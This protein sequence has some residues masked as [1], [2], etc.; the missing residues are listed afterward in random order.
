MSQA[1]LAA[2][3]FSTLRKC[4][5]MDAEEWRVRGWQ[6]MR[7]HLERFG[8]LDQGEPDEATI[9]RMLLPEFRHA[10]RQRVLRLL[11]DGLAQSPFMPAFADRAET[12]RLLRDRFPRERASLLS[13]ADRAVEA[14]F[15]LLGWQDVSFGRP[16]DWRLEPHAGK[17]TALDHWSRVPYLDAARVGDKKLVWE[18]NRHGHLVTL[19]QA[20]W[21]TQDERYADAAVDHLVSWMDA[22][23]PR[24]GINWASTL[25]VSFRSMAW[26]W[27]IRFLAGSPRLTVEFR[28]RLLKSLLQ[29][30]RYIQSYLSHYFSPNTHLTGEALGLFYLGTTLT[31]F[32]EAAGW[33]QQG[34]EILLKQ[35]PAQVREDGVYFEQSSYYHR[36]TVDFY[37]HLVLR[38]RAAR[39][40]LPSYV[41]RTLTA[42]L[43]HLMWITKPDGR[44]PLYGDDDGGRLLPLSTRPLDDFRDTLAVGAALYDRADWKYVAGDA[45]PEVLWL[46][47]PRAFQRW[48]A[49]PPA[50]PQGQGRLFEASG[51]AVVRDGWTERASYLLVDGGTH[52]GLRCGHAHA[53]A[54]SFEFAAEG[55][56]WI[57]DPGTYTYT[58]DPAARDAFRTT[59]GHNTVLVDGLSQ[60]VPDG[61]FSWQHIAH[62]RI[63]T[64]DTD[65]AGQGAV[66][67]G[68][69][70]GYCRLSSPVRHARAFR[71][72]KRG[73]RP[74]GPSCLM[75]TD[76][77][78][79][80]GRH[81]YQV[82]L[83][84]CP[85]C[86]ASVEAGA[87]RVSHASGKQLMV[88]MKR[89]T[90]DG[91]DSPVAIRMEPGWISR[92]YG[93]R[94][95][96]L[97]L[98]GDTEAEGDVTLLT[99]IV[100]VQPEDTLS[101]EDLFAL[102][103]TGVRPEPQHA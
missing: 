65:M 84:F 58:G 27:A 30:A 4:G 28:W 87:V 60:S 15:D 21:L 43:D 71:A 1:S 13:R 46:A 74:D 17:R 89:S 7:K 25:E 23:P 34:L 102:P 56:S 51:Y 62:A 39:V 98:A 86:E 83:H 57:V 88:G 29:H 19:G 91:D 78:S 22:N 18:L 75:I 63:T 8:G 16:V 92:C 50:A 85:G 79:T 52:G 9:R 73:E 12:V 10:S 99:A 45:A 72:A 11:Y 54:L 14:R 96:S 32:T 6:A 37:L 2:R 33:R 70:D 59:A 97:V 100:P 103:S 76:K 90:R 61:P 5:R 95:P 93:S 38:A 66:I 31:A 77:L 53:D 48:D 67:E 24:R 35:L 47:G 80:D 69:Q 41:D 20:Y 55:V 3:V 42:M 49:M 101:L 68:A 44:S 64:F 36:Y 40:V 26:L 82:R 81:R 94:E